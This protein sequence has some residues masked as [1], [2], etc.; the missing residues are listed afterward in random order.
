MKYHIPV[1]YISIKCSK[2]IRPVFGEAGG[3]PMTISYKRCTG[4]GL[5]V[6]EGIFHAKNTEN[7]RKS[8]YYADITIV[9][10]QKAYIWWL[11]RTGRP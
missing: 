11:M 3:I 7:L 10:L 1:L 2:R 5:A 9:W 8:I 6:R 4:S